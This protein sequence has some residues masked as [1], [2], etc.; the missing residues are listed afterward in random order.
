MVLLY[1]LKGMGIAFLEALRR[2][3]GA[4]QEE[5]FQEENIPY[6]KNAM[7]ISSLFLFGGALFEAFYTARLVERTVFARIKRMR[8]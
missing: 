8:F 6:S 4:E 3:E 1:H 2:H 7:P 5:I